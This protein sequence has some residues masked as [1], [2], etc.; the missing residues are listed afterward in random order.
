MICSLETCLGLPPQ[1]CCAASASQHQTTRGRSTELK[2]PGPHLG[3][4]VLVPSPFRLESR[5]W[6]CEPQREANLDEP[7][8]HTPLKARPW[9]SITCFTPPE[10]LTQVNPQGCTSSSLTC[11]SS[12]R[13]MLDT[14]CY[15]T[16][17][18]INKSLL[19]MVQKCAY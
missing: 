12:T 3:V 15:L 17:W 11:L 19:W 6:I 7:E 10:I 4:L 13:E 18:G 8:S 2:A 1:V 14:E 16:L 9:M 5:G